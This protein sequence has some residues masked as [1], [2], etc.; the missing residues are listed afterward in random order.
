MLEAT[1]RCVPVGNGGSVRMNPIERVHSFVRLRYAFVCAQE[2]SPIVQ[3]H[4][5]LPSRH[6]LNHLTLPSQPTDDSS[7]TPHHLAR[8]RRATPSHPLASEGTVTYV[9]A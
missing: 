8:K 6:Q 7:D 3:I 9:S 2:R 1:L 5:S 4:Y